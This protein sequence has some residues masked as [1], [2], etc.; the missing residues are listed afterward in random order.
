MRI[1]CDHAIWQAFIDGGRLLFGSSGDGHD[2]V[3]L[4]LE[5]HPHALADDVGVVGEHDPPDDAHWRLAIREIAVGAEVAV[6]SSRPETREL[7]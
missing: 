3:A 1:F 6:A 5:R 4:V 2:L 7:A